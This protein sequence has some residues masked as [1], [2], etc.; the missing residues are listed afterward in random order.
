VATYARVSPKKQVGNR[1]NQQT[2]ITDAASAKFPS[3]TIRGFVDVGSGLNFKRPGLRALLELCMQR[4]VQAVVVA[5]RDRLCRFGFELI[6]WLLGKYDTRILVLHSS[7]P[8][9]P[10]ALSEDLLAVV[11][12][13]SARAHGMRKYKRTLQKELEG[14]EDIATS[15]KR[16]KRTQPTEET[17]TEA[18]Q[19][20]AQATTGGAQATAGGAQGGEDHRGQVT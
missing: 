5:Y 13:F 12:V 15:T 9:T 1:V 11:A 3:K 6:E 8:N 18:D 4:R 14:D 20:G 10:D 2:E 19:G 16:A 17:N 7:P